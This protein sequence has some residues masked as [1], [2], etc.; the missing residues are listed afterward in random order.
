MRDFLHTILKDYE[1]SKESFW[2]ADAFTSFWH[3]F[4][5]GLIAV[6]I[7]VSAIILNKQSDK[8]KKKVLDILPFI[9][10]GLYISDLFLRP[11]AQLEG[12]FQQSIGGYLDKLPFHICTAMGVVCVFAQ[13][14]KKLSFIKGPFV[15]LSIVG[16]LMYVVAP[17]G[18]FGDRFAL[19]YNTLQTIAFHGVL[20]AWGV[21]SITTG[22][23]KVTIKNWYKTL[24]LQGV[25]FFWALFGNIIFS[26]M[27]NAQTWV[28]SGY[29]WF[30]LKSGAFYIACGEL[31]YA[32]IAPIG[33]F[34][35]IYLVAI[36][37]YG[38]AHLGYFI[39][40]KC[41]K[42]KVVAEEKVEETAL[43]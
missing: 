30:F 35:A 39:A 13:H 29:D 19:C 17:I 25:L 23:V 27:T 9:V 22:Q 36:G 33:V 41:K 7:I 10:I 37:V 15:I 14:S 32:I 3:Y 24:A 21:L 11:I 8:V 31:W 16:P 18:V 26:D 1:V 43:V 38:C 28:D 12:D 20:M 42:N 6:C 5:F 4:Y 2:H 34:C 40:G